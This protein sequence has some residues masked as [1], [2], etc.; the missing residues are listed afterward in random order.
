MT[1][2]ETEARSARS[3]PVIV[4]VVLPAY[5]GAAMI[6]RALDSA[7]S[8]DVPLRVIVVDDGSSD[9]S[10]EIARS[11]GPR[12]HVIV[13][14]N[15]GVSG[16][17]NTALAA[18]TAP[19]VAFL[20][21]DDV[22]KPGKLRRQVT[23]IEQHP[24]V[25]MVFTDMTIL[26]PDGTIVED[27]FLS[28]TLPYATL[29]RQPLGDAAFLLADRLA[30]AIVRENFISPS[31]TLVRT[32]AVMGIGGFDPQFRLADDAECWMRLLHRW[33]AIAI[34]DRLVL[35]Y[36]WGGNA[37][38]VKWRNLTE[39]RLRIGEKVQARPQLFPPD[40]PAYFRKEA[41]VAHYKLGLGALR[42]G[43]MRVAR[44]H[45]LQ[46]LRMGGSPVAV[47]ALLATI[48]PAPIRGALLKLKRA[49]GLRWTMR[50]E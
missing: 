16:A 12:V 15:Q 39:E 2:A 48:V 50:V 44:T 1:R 38:L 25:G 30:A 37:S 35:S 49:A 11:Y 8:Q 3:G 14:A 10:A 17:R 20:D 4:D 6:R 41:P 33:R 22:W 26:E 18:V 13:Q 36:R 45:L 32:A 21:Q 47:V 29:G 27:G 40:A 7:L 43:E 5:N 23:L 9:D 31:S 46:S 28:S 19:Y 24:G 34:E 42:E